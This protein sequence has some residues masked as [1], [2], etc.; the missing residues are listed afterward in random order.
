MAVAICALTTTTESYSYDAVGNRLSSLGMSPYVYNSSNELTSTPSATF[1]YDSNGNTLTK[2]DSSG[3]TTYNWDFENR[4]TLVVLPGTGETA[5]FMYD[6]SGRRIQKNSSGGTTNYLYDGSNSIAEVD[7]AGTLLATYV[8][9]GAIDEPLAQLRNGAAG[10]YEQDG[11]GSVTSIAGTAGT[12]LNSDTYDSFGN[13]TALTGSFGNPFQYT[14]R[15]NDSETGLRYYRARY[16][17]PSVGR[18]IS[19]DPIRFLGGMNF[20]S[21]VSNNPIDFRDPHGLCPPEVTKHYGLTLPCVFS[22]IQVMGAVESDFGWFGDYSRWG[23]AE[24]VMFSPPAGMSSGSTIPISVG[25]IGITQDMTVTVQSMNSQSMTFTTTPGH[26]LYPAY[27]TF[28]ATPASSGSINFNIDL[29]GTVASPMKFAFGGGAF[30]DA[31]WNHFLD[32]IKAFCK[33]RGFGGGGSG[34]AGVSGQW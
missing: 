19:N 25:I 9:S 34:G 12:L 14:G 6:P 1:T 21:Y 13:P 31:Q 22:A 7:T 33:W 30:E 10:Y 26:L 5:T 15:D 28:G 3:T 18:F 8:Q 29:G 20:Y 11:L 27:I 2:T 23:G 4:L 24:S 17:A 32:R 16:Y